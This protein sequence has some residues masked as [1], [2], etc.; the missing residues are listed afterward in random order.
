M[1]EVLMHPAA[2]NAVLRFAMMQ[3]QD[4]ENP[5]LPRTMRGRRDIRKMWNRIGVARLQIRDDG[6]YM[7]RG[8]L[9]FRID[10]EH[11][12]VAY[13]VDAEQAEM[14]RQAD[15]TKKKGAM[16][17]QQVEG[18]WYVWLKYRPAKPGTKARNQR[19]FKQQ[20]AQ[21]KKPKVKRARLYGGPRPLVSSQQS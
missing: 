12:V 16:F 7:L 21:T 20:E 18:S 10:D 17:L 11:H 8:G 6:W 1:L 4:P 19:Y 9:S 13:F 15:M 14:V 5:A 2:A 3:E